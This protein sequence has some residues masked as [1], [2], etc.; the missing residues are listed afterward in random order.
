MSK[1]ITGHY[2]NINIKGDTA[3]RLVGELSKL[4]MPIKC[5]LADYKGDQILVNFEGQK[6]FLQEKNHS[7]RYWA[8]NRETSE[9]FDEVN[10]FIQEE[11]EI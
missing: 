9:H 3:S 6:I 8:I 5:N 2:Y 11:M 4:K 1:L 10:L 7:L